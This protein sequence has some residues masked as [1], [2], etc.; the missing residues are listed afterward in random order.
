VRGPD[1]TKV[2]DLQLKNLP[3][4]ADIRIVKETA[5]VRHVISATVEEDNMKGICTGMGRI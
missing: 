2:V 3:A 4:N 5:G 1:E